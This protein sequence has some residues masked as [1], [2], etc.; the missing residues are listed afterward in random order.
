MFSF[1]SFRLCFFLVAATCTLIVFSATK[2]FAQKTYPE[3]KVSYKI[4]STQGKQGASVE[5]WLKNSKYVMIIKGV[6]T[7][8]ELKTD[9]G[10]TVT[11]HD[12]KLKSGALMNEYGNQK[13]LVRLA[14]S[15]IADRDKKYEGVEISLRDEK[16][17]IAGYE[18]LLA[19]VQLKDGTVFRVFYSPA[20]QFQNSQYDS[21]FHDLPGFPLEFESTI[22]KNI[23]RYIADQI[24]FA[25]VPS[26]LFDIP[27]TG[28]KEMSY[29]EVKSM[30]SN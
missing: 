24:D 25:S 6:Q 13:I 22:G 19:L 8:T 7:R 1:N 17:T 23:Y 21:P 5:V 20:L 9:A 15:D 30:Q 12:S 2:G 28:Y 29:A 18:C 10:S 16:K 11:I 27:K 26:S 4:E 14:A 3:G